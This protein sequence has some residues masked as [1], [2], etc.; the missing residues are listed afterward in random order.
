M[1]ECACNA[2]IWRG[3]RNTGKVSCSN[4][5][6][7]NLSR[8]SS[9]IIFSATPC[10]PHVLRLSVEKVG[11]NIRSWLHVDIGSVQQRLHGDMLLAH[12]DSD[13]KRPQYARP[14]R[15]QVSLLSFVFRFN[16]WEENRRWST[17]IEDEDMPFS[18]TS[19]I[20]R[21]SKLSQVN[22]R[23]SI[24]KGVRCSVD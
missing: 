24:H 13:F 5:H 22:K 16:E 20:A 21:R 23:I 12:R 7:G 10:S 8:Q 2:C 6:V 9:T 14:Q 17:S 11:Q 1:T 19:I 18:L 4:E 15:L 3:A